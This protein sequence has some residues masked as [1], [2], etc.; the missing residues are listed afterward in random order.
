MSITIKRARRVVRLVADLGLAAEH[1]LADTELQRVQTEAL[2]D[3]M[4]NG[5]VPAA[6]ARVKDAEARM[7]AA[8]V[9]VTV[10]ALPH[11][12][13]AE[14]VAEHPPRDGD[15]ND[16]AAG[17]DVA[18]AGEIIAAS[19]VAATD[20]SGHPVEFDWANVADDLALGQWFDFAGAVATVNSPQ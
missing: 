11:K 7:D 14:W 12:R 1:E 17:F 10:E 3:P 8:T 4:E 6:L 5:A 18:A 20:T 19:I 16:Q 15:T 9:L 13:W 2:T